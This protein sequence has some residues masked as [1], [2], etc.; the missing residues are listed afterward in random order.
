[1]GPFA[2]IVELGSL[3]LSDLPV[4]FIYLGLNDLWLTSRGHEDTL[5]E[6]KAVSSKMKAAAK[7]DATYQA[8][9][10]QYLEKVE[11]KVLEQVLFM[12]M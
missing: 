7:D 4:S 12:M 2:A 8:S 6:V 1:M 10:R 5:R 3:A 11:K 9:L